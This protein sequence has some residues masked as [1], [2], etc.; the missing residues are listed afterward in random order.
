[1]YNECDTLMQCTVNSI[2]HDVTMTLFV[3]ESLNMFVLS[4]LQPHVAMTVITFNHLI[5]HACNYTVN[6]FG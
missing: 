5:F 3:H 4:L 6:C 2:T 1:M